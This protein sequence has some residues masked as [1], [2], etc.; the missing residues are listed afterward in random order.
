[1]SANVIA[2]PVAPS[3]TLRV[4]ELRALILRSRAS[5]AAG[6]ALP[7][8]S[9]A[10]VPPAAQPRPLRLVPHRYSPAD[11]YADPAQAD[12]AATLQAL[13]THLE[14]VAFHHHNVARYTAP[15]LEF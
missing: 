15:E 11:S 8:E 10:P 1:M 12:T 4:P 9:A 13:R 14:Q 6:A 3:P 2:L 5:L 7:T